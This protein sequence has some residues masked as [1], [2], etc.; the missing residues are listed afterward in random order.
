MGDELEVGGLGKIAS[1]VAEIVKAVCSFR[2]LEP[3]N[4]RIMK[5]RRPG[6]WKRRHKIIVHLQPN[7][8]TTVTDLDPTE[9]VKLQK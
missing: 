6:E 5:I 3:C 7:G 1:A 2:T 4:A 8:R 9:T